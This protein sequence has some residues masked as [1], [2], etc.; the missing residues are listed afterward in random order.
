MVHSH[1]NLLS[2]LVMQQANAWNGDN[3]HWKSI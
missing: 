3:G 1:A 2:K